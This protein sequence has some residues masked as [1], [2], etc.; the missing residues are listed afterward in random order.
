M[1]M[2][3]RTALT[4]ALTAGLAYSQRLH[5]TSRRVEEMETQQQR[6]LEVETAS[7]GQ[8]TKQKSDLVES[9]PGLDPALKVTQHAGRIPLGDS[10]KNSLFY[11][12]FKAS[13]DAEKAPLVIWYGS[14]GGNFNK[15]DG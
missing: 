1:T 9:L 3:L 15:C 4:A 7:S 14:T 5:P 12:H 6:D 13:Q 10:D 11:W 2:P 8:K